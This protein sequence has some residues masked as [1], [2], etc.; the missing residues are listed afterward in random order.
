MANNDYAICMKRQM[1]EVAFY[2]RSSRLF[3]FSLLM[4]FISCIY[5]TLPL[6]TLAD[7][8]DICF[9][10]SHGLPHDISVDISALP[11]YK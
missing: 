2:I 7:C 1:Q 4:M 3:L 8:S 5:K 9:G 6:Q 10:T 11:Y